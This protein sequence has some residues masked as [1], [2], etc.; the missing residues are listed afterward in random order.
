MP[1]RISFPRFRKGGTVRRAPLG[2]LWREALSKKNQ[3]RAERVFRLLQLSSEYDLPEHMVI[4]VASECGLH[5]GEDYQI[6]L[7][8]VNE[9][10]TPHGKM[11]RGWRGGWIQRGT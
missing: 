10:E 2:D 5:D 1:A 3:E 6:R 7:F 11:V 9:R 4:P 8:Y